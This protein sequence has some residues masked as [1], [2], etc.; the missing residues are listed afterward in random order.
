MWQ[1]KRVPN[2]GLILTLEDASD[3]NIHVTS[4]ENGT[5]PKLLLY[6]ASAPPK[7]PDMMPLTALKPLGTM[8]QFKTEILTQSLNKGNVGA[9][10]KARLLAKGGIAPYAWKATGLPEGLALAEDGNLTGKP[11]KAGHYTLQLTV[12]GS[13]KRSASGKIDLEIGGEEKTAMAG[14]DPKTPDAPKPEKKSGGLED[15]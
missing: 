13:D 4:R 11:A 7:N 9:D 10:Y 5:K 15:E 2:Y 3:M 1:A 12:T 6:Y 8:P 14:A